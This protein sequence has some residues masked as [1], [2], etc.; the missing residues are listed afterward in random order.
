[1]LVLT[2]PTAAVAGILGALPETKYDV[3]VVADHVNGLAVRSNGEVVLLLD[4]SGVDGGALAELRRI[5]ERPGQPGGIVLRG[6]PIVID[7]AHR[8]V[9]VRGNVVDLTAL[10]LKLLSYLLMHPDEP[11]TRALLLESVWGHSV[12]SLATVTVHV[13]R[14]R[15]KVE[16][17]P[18]KPTLILTVWGV[19]YRFSSDGDDVRNL[20]KR[21]QPRPE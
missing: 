4:V 12:G 8:R 2:D 1:V 20:M 16:A 19:G 10:E 3:R 18:S 15:E 13:R 17:D 9:E 11:I 5:I 7:V 21:S 14:L 6:G